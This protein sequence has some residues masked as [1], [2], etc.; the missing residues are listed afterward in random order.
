MIRVVERVRDILATTLDP[1]VTAAGHFA[2]GLRQS[3][4]R[5]AEACGV[6]QVVQI[7]QVVVAHARF[8]ASSSTVVLSAHI[9]VSY[10]FHPFRQVPAVKAHI[11]LVIAIVGIVQLNRLFEVLVNFLKQ[12]SFKQV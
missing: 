12:T 3:L 7:W 8:S 2:H 4:I 9:V 10:L 6:G 11:G 5:T 1:R